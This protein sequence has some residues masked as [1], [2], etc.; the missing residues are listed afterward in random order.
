MPT[1]AL[2]GIDVSRY[3]GYIDYSSV[4]ASGIEIVYIRSSL[5][6]SYVDPYFRQNYNNA[7]AN[8]LKV[9]FYHYVIARNVT[10]AREEARFFA[11]TISGLQPDCLLAMDFEQLN[12]LSNYEVNQISLAFLQELENLTNKRAV[13][14]SDSYN[15]NNVFD[16]TIASR[17]PLWLAQ[18]GVS[19]P[20]PG[21]WSNWIGWQY[22]D[23]GEIP[24]INGY[25]DRDTFTNSILLN[26]TT[27]IENPDVRDEDSTKTIYYRVKS[28]DT[29]YA[30]ASQYGVTV[31]DL[32]TWNNISNPNLIYPNQILTIYTHF[33]KQITNVNASVTTYTV[34]RGD[35]IFMG[36]NEYKIKVGNCLIKVD[37]YF[38]KNCRI[39]EVLE[40][41][42]QNL[43]I[44]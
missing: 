17:Y 25:V 10:E 3:Q 7:K 30:I 38:S 19:S 26:D 23:K 37:F 6:N 22:T 9:G 8:G 40:I 32:V 42:F 39:Q 5:G 20:N 29:L 14:Y 33:T 1:K 11:S 15:A 2:E 4:R 16:S 27:P 12:G 13:V 36:N 31:N 28:G 18:Y 21:N 44:C 34:K 35:T 24:G 41:F 43:T